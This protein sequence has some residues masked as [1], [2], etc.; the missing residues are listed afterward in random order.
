MMAAKPEETIRGPEERKCN[1]MVT[2]LQTL[3]STLEDSESISIVE[4]AI[5]EIEA[6]ERMLS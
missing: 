3:I 6:L 5:K 2:K 1:H 4:E